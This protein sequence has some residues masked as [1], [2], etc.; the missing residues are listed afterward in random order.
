MEYKQ[1]PTLRLP[2]PLH[3]LPLTAQKNPISNVASDA[4]DILKSEAMAFLNVD[5]APLMLP[6]FARV[7]VQGRPKFTRVV[8]QQTASANKDMAIITIIDLP[9]SEIPFAEVRNIILGL[10]EGQYELR[11]MDIQRCPFHRA[12]AYVRMNRVTNRDALVHHNPHQF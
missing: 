7:L 4:N 12:Q 9:P 6:S 1:F 3:L 11:V 2:R 5:P 8:N 10:L